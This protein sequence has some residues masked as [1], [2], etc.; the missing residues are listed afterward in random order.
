MYQQSATGWQGA[1]PAL[2]WG[3]LRCLGLHLGQLPVELCAVKSI[4][5][6]EAELDMFC[7]QCQGSLEGD[8]EPEGCH[9]LCFR[10]PGQVRRPA[11]GEAAVLI[12]EGQIE[13][14]EELGPLSQI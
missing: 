9:F 4:I 1:S 10:C 12:E 13:G 8:S 14:G 11:Q 2:V 5:C 7:Q 6:L 3:S